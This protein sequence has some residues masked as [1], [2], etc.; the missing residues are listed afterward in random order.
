MLMALY[1]FVCCLWRG[2]T[3]LIELAVTLAAGCP[4]LRATIHLIKALFV[5]AQPV[6]VGF[7][8]HLEH[9]DDPLWK[10]RV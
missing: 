9:V 10:F 5:P 6:A 8:C 1:S 7:E 2:R 4:A 3:G